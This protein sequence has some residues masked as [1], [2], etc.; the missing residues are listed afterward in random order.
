MESK[1]AVLNKYES[2]TKKENTEVIGGS[3]TALAALG[4]W[5]GTVSVGLK[6]GA[7]LGNAWDAIRR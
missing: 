6:A 1:F 3:V 2:L 7:A 4:I 5:A